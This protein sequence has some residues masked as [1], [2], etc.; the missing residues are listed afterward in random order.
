MAAAKY[1]PGDTV[2]TYYSGVITEHRV[3]AV[4]TG[5]VSQTG[6]LYQITPRLTKERD[7]PKDVNGKSYEEWIDEGWFKEKR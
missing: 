3:I 4:K 5:Q 1:K 2:Y 6:V 7:R